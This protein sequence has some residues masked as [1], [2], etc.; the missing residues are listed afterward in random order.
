MRLIFTF[1]II[2]ILF[3]CQA[4][5]NNIY[6]EDLTSLRKILEKTPSYK[7]QIR[8]QTLTDYNKLFEKLKNDST[9]RISD[10]NYF[11]NLAQLFFPI[12]DNH[13]GFYQIDNFPKESNYPKFNGNIDSL[14]TALEL[15]PLDSIE[16][17]YY[18]G[19]SYIIGL[20]ENK[21][22]EYIGVVINPK[23]TT[24]KNGQIVIHL[25]EMLPK[26]FKAIYAH[27]KYKYYI[28]YQIEKFSNYSLVNSY[29]YSS[30]SESIYSKVIGKTDYI[31]LPKGNYPF[32]FKNITSDI[33]YLKIK[34]FSA[35]NVAMKQSQVFYDSIKNSLSTPN[36]ILDLRNNEGGAFKVSAKFLKLITGYIKSG[37]VY[38]LANNGTMSQ[39]EIFTLQLKQ[40]KNVKIL[41]QTTKG[42]L[43][44]GS[45]YGK[46]EKLTS[47][48]FEIYITDLGGDRRLIP[49]ENYG[50]NPDVTLTGEE[51]WIEQTI[52]IINKK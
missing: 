29:F 39:G 19:D 33:Q 48:S 12:Q 34:N 38:I 3:N 9:Y 20:F 43:T 45:N 22:K 40:L 5:T 24:W 17:I 28:F 6:I 15:K 21:P 51:D 13:L 42:T 1:L 52:S 30:F 10:Y 2:I 46:R 7:D 11:Y 37:Q 25:Y 32:Q 27:P 36:L 35:D 44:Y 49:Y 50:I 16:G 4:Q 18:Y 47:K 31:N 14:I 8:G 26:Y 23:N 41:G